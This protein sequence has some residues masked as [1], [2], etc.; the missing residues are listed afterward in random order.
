VC[1]DSDS[2]S[3]DTSPHSPVYAH[4]NTNRGG[5]PN[6]HCD[7][8]LDDDGNPD[9]NAQ[10][11]TERDCHTLDADTYID[12]DPNK[13]VHDNRHIHSDTDRDR[14]SDA[15]F[16]EQPDGSTNRNEHHYNHV[17][18]DHRSDADCDPDGHADRNG[19]QRSDTNSY[20][21]SLIEPDNPTDGYD[22]ADANAHS[23]AVSR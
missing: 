5:L 13:Y 20:R 4:T 21:D 18:A 14:Y 22:N 11:L 23:Q 7:A 19:H 17:D 3:Y 6:Q 2:N 12:C 1:G 15:N 9:N 16:D 10:Q 8:N